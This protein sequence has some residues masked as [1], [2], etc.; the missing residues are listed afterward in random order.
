MA[1]ARP[2]RDLWMLDDASQSLVA[3]YRDLTGTTLDPEVLAAFRRLWA[4]TD[5]A[6]FTVQLRRPHEQDA[7]ADRALAGLLS[8]LEGREP[9]P[10]GAV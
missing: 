9:A 10:F 4:L 7:D 1:V 2:E 8:I 5:V 3:A 6:A